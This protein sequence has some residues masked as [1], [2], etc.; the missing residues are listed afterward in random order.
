MKRVSDETTVDLLGIREAVKE[1][2]EQSPREILLSD[3][4]YD[5]CQVD[6]LEDATE[7]IM[8]KQVE[9]WHYTLEEMR[10]L[11]HWECLQGF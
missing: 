8:N 2:W 11:W 5:E 7:M 1:W 3:W 6:N 4:N 10:D 9:D